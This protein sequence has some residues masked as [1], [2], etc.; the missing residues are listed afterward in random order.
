MAG[1]KR[2]AEEAMEEEETPMMGRD[3]AIRAASSQ[4]V[5]LAQKALA[6]ALKA[7]KASA[8]LDR[9]GASLTNNSDIV[10]T[11][12]TQP[13]VVVLFALKL[14]L[15]DNTW[16]TI[17]DGASLVSAMEAWSPATMTPEQTGG[18]Q[19]FLDKHRED[20]YFQSGDHLGGKLENDLFEWV[21]A[22]FTIATL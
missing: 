10:D 20:E 13:V 18:A 14:L 22:A 2:N 12:G 7:I 3:E 15:G 19:D 1:G 17:R 21:D 4:L 5:V 9:F 8:D 6:D 16:S 11:P